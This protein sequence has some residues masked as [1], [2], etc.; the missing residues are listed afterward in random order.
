M[1]AFDAIHEGISQAQGLAMEESQFNGLA[2]H[3]ELSDEARV[4]LTQNINPEVGLMN[5]TQAVVKQIVYAPGTHPNHENPACRLPACI[6]VD[7]PKYTGPIFFEDAAKRT[8]VPI[9]PRT[10][11]DAD[12][13]TITRTQF[14]VV[15]GWALTPWKAQGMTLRLSSSWAWQF[16][17]L[18]FCSS[19]SHVCDIQTTSCLM[20]N[21]Q[22][23]LKS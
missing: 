6:L 22:L 16:E 7:V 8:W 13:R 2:S 12:N 3:V 10:I 19:L 23:F 5:G 18:A 9:F 17:N 1:V 20:M 15:L 4:I 21:S 11:S 14:P